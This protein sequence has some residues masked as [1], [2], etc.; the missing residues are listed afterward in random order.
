MII[1]NI[2]L[3]YD[4]GQPIKSLLGYNIFCIN[5]IIVYI[6]LALALLGLLKILEFFVCDGD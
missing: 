4:K 5:E 3:M 6:I 1:E 2:C